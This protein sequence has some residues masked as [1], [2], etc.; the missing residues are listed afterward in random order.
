MTDS[1]Q[2]LASVLGIDV[3][4]TNTQVVEFDPITGKVVG[5]RFYATQRF[6][7]CDDLIDKAMT[8]SVRRV[9]GIYAVM[10][11]PRR[12]DGRIKM[13][14]IEHWPVF[15]P[16][17]S[18]ARLDI[19]VSTGN[20]MKGAAA[21]QSK[22]GSSDCRIVKRGIACV[23]GPRLVVT[24][25]SGLGDGL[26]ADDGITVVPGE[27]G[28][29][30]WQPLDA[31][32]FEYLMFLR[33]RYGQ[34]GITFE[35]A[36]SGGHGF[37]NLFDYLEQRGRE[38]DGHPLPTD[39]LRQEVV[40]RLRNDAPIG[41][42]I[43]KAAID[44]DPFCRAI[45]EV[46]GSI[47][48]QYLRS[49]AVATLPTGGIYLIGGVSQLAVVDYFVLKTSFLDDFVMKGVRHDDLLGAIPV[50][51]VTT[52]LLGALGAAQLAAQAYTRVMAIT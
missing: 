49:R 31:T 45:M 38:T 37:P 14:N 17:A 29:T 47:L 8:E 43:S 19:P 30:L 25:S 50:H 34:R 22:L 39:E 24:V 9:A 48:G 15:N 4:G 52:D 5:T 46:F 41:D 10:A 23:D 7:S 20:D 12:D 18:S 35:L 33:N 21:G 26:L 27:A 32:Q 40:D 36:M 13:T 28:H 3:G 1:I 42:L 44:G 51:V 2:E 6:A 16:T 11:G